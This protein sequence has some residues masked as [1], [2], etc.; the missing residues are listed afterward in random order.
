MRTGLGGSAG[1][2]VVNRNVGRAEVGP[3]DAKA[4]S[5]APV[6]IVE[7]RVESTLQSLGPLFPVANGDLETKAALTH[8]VPLDLPLTVLENCFSLTWF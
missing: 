2:L 8:S 1:I 5:G 3:T 7:G 6:R 4:E